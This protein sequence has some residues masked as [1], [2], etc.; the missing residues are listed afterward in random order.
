MEKMYLSFP[1]HR[2][3]MFANNAFCICIHMSKEFNKFCIILHVS[4]AFYLAAY[5]AEYNNNSNKKN[6]K[7]YS[8]N[9]NDKNLLFYAHI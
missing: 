3:N 4:N 1:V 5:V 6:G 9:K 2:R 7:M 8:Q